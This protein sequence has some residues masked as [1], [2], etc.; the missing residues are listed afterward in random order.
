MNTRHFALTDEIKR[1]RT[2]HTCAACDGGI[3]VGS[4]AVKVTGRTPEG[5]ASAYLH[6]GCYEATSQVAHEVLAEAQSGELYQAHHEAL[7][8]STLRRLPRYY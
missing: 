1:T 2:P 6:E 4:A 5:F 7:Y 3:R 8:Q